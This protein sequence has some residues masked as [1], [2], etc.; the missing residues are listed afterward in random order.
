MVVDGVGGGCV[1][2]GTKKR[3][4]KIRKNCNSISRTKIYMVETL[5]KHRK[6]LY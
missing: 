4:G 1:G 2:K 6:K 5:G 3:E